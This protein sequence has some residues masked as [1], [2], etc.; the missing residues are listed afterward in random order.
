MKLKKILNIILTAIGIALLIGA[1][2]GAAMSCNYALILLIPSLFSLTYPLLSLIK[3]I[4]NK[5]KLNR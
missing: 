1:G 5:Y 4:Y 2:V 3:N